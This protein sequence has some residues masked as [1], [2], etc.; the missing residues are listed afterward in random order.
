MLTPDYLQGL[1]EELERLYLQLE[2]EIIADICRRLAKFEYITDSS[3]YEI[4]R[5][6]ELGAG[7]EY[8]KKKISEYSGL[9]AEMCD[10]LFFDAAQTSSEYYEKLYSK[11][12][13]DYTPFEY[14]DYFQQTVR[15]AVNQTQ[16]TLKNLTASMGCSYRHAN[17]QIKFAEAVT[18]YRDCLDFAATQL[19]SGA[20]TY[21][22][23]IRAATRKLTD[24]GL[25][26]VDYASGVKN[27]VDVAVRR[28][29][30]TGV[31]QFEGKI[32]ESNAAQLDTDI[33]EVSAH[34]G[35]RPD[36]AEWQGKWYSL[37]GKSDKYPSLREA[38]GYGT[39]TG[40]K[41]ANC[42]HDFYPVIDGISEPMYTEEELANIDKPPFE[43]DGKT[44]TEYEATQRQRYMERAIRKTKRELL[45][46]EET[47]DE[48]QFTAKSVLLRRQR[49]EYSKFSKAAG[50]YTRSELTQVQ[51]FGHSQASK[52]AWSERKASGNGGL[53][54][55]GGS[56]MM[57][58]RSGIKISMQFFAEKDIKNQKSNSLNR[59]I[60]KYQE[61]I[62]EHKDKI[63]N[64]QK[65]VPDWDSYSE[66]RKSGLKKH[67][68]KEINN[69]EE[70]IQN[71]ID[72][73]KERGDYDE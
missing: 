36:H 27:H 42:R 68:Q 2:N 70:S 41:G 44:Y 59:A 33:V 58:T 20:F 60:R 53:T 37:S 30:L 16:G 62:D 7:T 6:K 46:A 66:K 63:N 23:A 39:V 56:G 4:L 45:A 29:V 34:S 9:S 67:W 10:R 57:N 28:A 14:N 12:N 22:E 8:I 51:S 52:A 15:A 49:D 1:P 54:N 25:Q 31:A 43:Y 55:S 40:L 11:A 3:E 73:L 17:G 19:S 48:E 38:T 65:Y 61:R 26:M 69:F 18:V 35:A 5:L 32:A 72:E 47:G 50:L 71:R 13:A 21:T 24:S 64:P